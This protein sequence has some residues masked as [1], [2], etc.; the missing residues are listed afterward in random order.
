VVADQPAR[1]ADQDR[2]EGRQPRRYV[3]FQIAEVGVPRQM[4]AEILSRIAR[5]R[6]PP[7]PA[8]AGMRATGQMRQTTPEV[9]PD[10]GR[11]TRFSATARSIG[12]L[13]ACRARGTRFAVAPRRPK[14]RL[15]PHNDSES[16]GCWLITTYSRAGLRLSNT[17]LITEGHVDAKRGLP[18]ENE[19]ESAPTQAGIRTV[20]SAPN[21][22]R[23]QSEGLERAEL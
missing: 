2:R 14:G 23:E 4:F 9:R 21:E 7:V 6:A 8:C 5:L 10:A 20:L 16:G 13:T 19:P 15:S 17:D 18:G 3:T 22:L 11:A 1:E 12:V